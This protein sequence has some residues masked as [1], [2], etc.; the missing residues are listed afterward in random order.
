MTHI[1]VYTL[2]DITATGILSNT[3]EN[4]HKRNQQRNWE[5]IHQVI[6]LRT[7]STII[8]VPGTPKLVNLDH[9][10]FGSYYHAPQRHTFHRCW[11]FIFDVQYL[12][13]FSFGN[14]PLERL[15][16]DLNN[17]PIITGLDETVDLPD[18]VFYI[19]GI[20]KNT[21]LKILDK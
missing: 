21:Y 20:L 16:Y 1:A 19:E 12:S 14:N 6:N 5:T 17:V 11:K 10:Q 15:E 13:V 18:P 8:A 9:Y 3:T 7:H 4:K 2:V